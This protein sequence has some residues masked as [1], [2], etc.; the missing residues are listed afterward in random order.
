MGSQF[1]N[2][3]ILHPL[4]RVDELS[5]E[6]DEDPRSLYFRQAAIGIPIRMSLLWHV[7]GLGDETVTTGKLPY[8]QEIQG[9]FY[10]YAG[11]DCS[12]ETCVTNQERLFASA[13][14]EVVM[15][16]DYKLRCLHCDQETTA[17]Y[18]GNTESRFYYPSG[19]LDR[20]LPLV[21]PEHV[22]FFQSIEDAESAGFKRA[23][24]KWDSYQPKQNTSGKRWL[25]S[26]SSRVQ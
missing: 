9:L 15:D 11:F 6:V 5:P 4:P 19:L 14:F 13:Q 10:S 20:F 2:I 21:R 24:G 17:A 16:G 12:N 18:A 7:L 8:T 22:R 23:S 26:V 1:E 25:N 3:S